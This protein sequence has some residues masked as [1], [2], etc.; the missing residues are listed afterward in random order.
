MALVFGD[1]KLSLAAEAIVQPEQRRTDW[2]RWASPAAVSLWLTDH[3][4]SN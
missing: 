4:V 3:I 2:G 1:D